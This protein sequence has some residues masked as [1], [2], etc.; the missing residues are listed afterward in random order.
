[1]HL[2]ATG[3]VISKGS[4]V[5]YAVSSNSSSVIKFGAVVKLKDKEYDERVYDRV[6]QTY[7]TKKKT[8]YSI[9]IVSVE[10]QYHYD[11]ATD[12]SAWRWV[13]QGKAAEGKPARVQSIERLDRV[14][15]LESHQVQPDVKEILDKELHFRGAI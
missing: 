13:V 6:T 12:T 8:G 11:Q 7:D 9:S 2:D 15:L 5:A 1:M 4:Y 14:L 10:K 3:R